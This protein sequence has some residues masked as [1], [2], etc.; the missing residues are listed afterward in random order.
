MEEPVVQLGPVHLVMIRLDNEALR[1][2]IADQI[3]RASDQK[4]IRVLDALAIRRENDNTFTTLEATELSKEQHQALGAVIGSLLGLGANGEIGAEE[5]AMEGAKKWANR[6]F[7]LSKKDIRSLAQDVPI[8]KT[9]L[10]ILFEHRWALGLK[11]AANRANGVVLAEGI[12]R[13]EDLIMEGANR[14]PRSR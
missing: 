2:E 13:P 14:P 6:T 12:V 8:G 10:I 5:G 9:V 3:T 1:G 4:I 7:G 11:Q